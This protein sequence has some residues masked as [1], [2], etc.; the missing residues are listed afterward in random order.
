MSARRRLIFA[1]AGGLFAARGAAAQTAAGGF[2]RPVILLVPYSAGSTNDI[3]ARMLAPAIGARLGQ[4]VPVD[5]RAGA[6]GT[7]GIAQVARGGRADAHVLGIVSTSTIPI[8]RALYRGLAYDPERDLTVLAVAASTPNAL[9]VSGAGPFRS[10]A[11]FLAAGRDAGRPPLR[12][13]SPGNGTSQHLSCL[14]FARA[15]GLRTE[16]VPYRG[17]S[18]GI[19]GLIAGETDWGFSAVPSIAGMARDGRMRVLGTT[20]TRPAA[21]LLEVP[22]FA[23]QGF[24]GFEETD[25]WYGVAVARDTPAEAAAVLR[26]AVA[27]ALAAPG[28][29]ERL[30]AAGFYPIAAMTPAETE[31]FVGRQ[32]AFW[33]ELVRESGARID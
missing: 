7:V 6:G 1:C 33:A 19:T 8:N 31:A 16:H 5:N 14:Q 15:A 17:P 3:L 29:R 12:Y 27:A 10:M 21:A 24:S 20:G 9:I 30:A 23:A 18:E 2:A 13:F 28:M 25:V 32:V 26:D 11:E 4:P 22:T